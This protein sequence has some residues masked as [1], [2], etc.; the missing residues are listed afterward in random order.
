MIISEGIECDFQN[1]HKPVYREITTN[2]DIY[3]QKGEHRVA[4]ALCPPSRL[5]SLPVK[6]M[7]WS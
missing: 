4:Y 2:Q 6:R 5:E 1:P 3:E 7:Y